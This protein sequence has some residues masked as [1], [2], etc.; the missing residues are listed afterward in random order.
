MT[1][2]IKF[3]IDGEWVEASPGMTILEAA[4][5]NGIYIPHLCFSDVTEPF[6]G[7]RLCLVE[8][9]GRLVIAC[10]NPAEEGMNIVSESGR[11]NRIRRNTVSLI[12]TNHS[13]DCLTCRKSGD[14][15]LQ[16]VASYL[17][18]SEDD[19]ERLRM[20]LKDV[21]PDDSNPFFIRDHDKCVL[22]GIC[23]RVCEYV[24]AEAIDFAY[25][26]HDTK[27]AAF[28][29]RD[30]MDSPCVSC[31]ECVE[32]CPVGAL[33][34]R[35]EKPSSEVKTVCPYCGA[36]CEIHLGVR[37]GR[38][39]SA[40]GVRESP[41]N[42][43]NLCVKGRFGLKFVNSPERLKKPLMKV[44]GR[45]VEVE[46]DEAIK[47]IAERLSE[48]GGS[49]FA[50]VAS[51]KCTNEENY[52]LQKFTRAVIGSGNID[53]CARL[54][55]APSVA[56][57]KMS[58]GSGAMTNSIDELRDAA[59][60]LAVGTNATETHPITGYRVLE[61][62]RGGSRLL[63]ID[64]R[65][66]RLSE[67]ADIHLRNRPGT[68]L[69]LIMA[70]SRFIIEEELQDT[71]FIGSRT[72]GF[73]EFREELF[74]LDLD[75]VQEI[76]GVPLEDIRRAA[77][78]YASN[79]PASIIYSM[80]VTQH[81]N[82]TGNVLAL[83]NLALLT[84]NIGMPSAGINPLRGQNNVQGSCDMGALPDLL[85]GYQGLDD[86]EALEKFSR[87]WDS[88]IPD[89]GKILP[90]IFEDAAGGR[91]KAM[92]I[93]GEN[94]LL[95]EPDIGKVREA[96]EKL[97]LLIVQDIFLTETSE[98]ADVVL[99]A[100]SFAE[101]DGTFTNTE[102]RVQ[103]IRKAI[104]PP[105]DAKPD[106]WIISRIAEA[107]GSGEFSY[108]TSE[109]IFDEIRGLVPSYA[110]LSYDRLESGGIQWPCRS[111]EDEGTPYLHADEFP[112]PGGRASFIVPGYQLPEG[113]SDEYPMILLTGRN[114][115]QYHTRSMTAR[116]RGLERFLGTEELLM[117]PEDAESLG[118]LDGDEVRVTS[119]RGSITVGVRVTER[120]MKG[121]VFMTFHFAESPANSLTSPVRDP[122]SGMP[123]LKATPVNIK[124]CK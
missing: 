42:R 12:I 46:W 3:K 73:D 29:D 2:T 92:Y 49:E 104:D 24:G 103:L 54:C 71:D 115:Y 105:G 39:V 60:I 70:M 4:L 35:T 120:V 68:D 21:P 76:T 1:G 84:G 79:S 63:V 8:S 33:S 13:R 95:S 85:P 55:H 100:A 65:I 18:V 101:K 82:G 78:I 10:E 121:T 119:V 27:I 34:P 56:G 122:V 90:E 57:L 96:F 51:A 114:L 52:L 14:C 107:M 111:Q 28:L 20:D 109:E 91:I 112:K 45:F 116:V 22:C 9:E 53:H 26:G 66:T 93:M 19:L 50:A 98:L 16:E 23:V 113:P 99:P 41:V 59:C 75:E 36:G 97:E 61:A 43:G 38:V 17:D 87:A 108:E 86:P 5:A 30:I 80:G 40:R 32:A 37:G 64:P 94:P 7:C 15:K 72:D 44:D 67:A 117:N 69:Y 48:Y 25:R 118:V 88:E 31:G 62:V 81:V 89:Y 11:I 58:L 47:F 102:R 110:G 74:K 77:R 6:G 106:W 83:S 124:P 123:G